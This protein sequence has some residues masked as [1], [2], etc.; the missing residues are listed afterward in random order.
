VIHRAAVSRTVWYGNGWSI[1]FFRYGFHLRR[2]N[3]GKGSLWRHYRVGFFATWRGSVRLIDY[4]YRLTKGSNAKTGL[5][6]PCW[7]FRIEIRI[8]RTEW[9]RDY[10][11]TAESA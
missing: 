1:H 4:S 8:G 10:P 9:R 2:R 11:E 5:I 7:R 3:G 6:R